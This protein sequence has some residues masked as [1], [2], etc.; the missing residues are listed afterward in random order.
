MF[1]L[2]LSILRIFKYF[3]TSSILD[4]IGHH[5]STGTRVEE[6]RKL[7]AEENLDIITCDNLDKAAKMVSLDNR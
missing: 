6:A 5:F 3:K 2:Y 7:I 4:F 1:L